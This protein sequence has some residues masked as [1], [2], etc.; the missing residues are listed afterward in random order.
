M[1]LVNYFW[2]LTTSLPNWAYPHSYTNDNDCSVARPTPT[3]AYKTAARTTTYF[4]I[5]GSKFLVFCLQVCHSD[6]IT[7]Y[8]AYFKKTLL[9]NYFTFIYNSCCY[10]FRLCCN[11]L[12]SPL[13]FQSESVAHCWIH[14]SKIEGTCF[15]T[16]YYL[17]HSDLLTCLCIQSFYLYI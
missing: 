8:D 3:K 13:K 1:T 2:T 11:R 9:H 16:P 4:R 15:G 6:H 14:S 5:F 7:R 12:F 10:Y 17:L